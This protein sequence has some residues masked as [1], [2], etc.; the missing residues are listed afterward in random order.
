M[1]IKDIRE[2]KINKLDT[3]SIEVQTRMKVYNPNSYAINVRE[4]NADLFLEGRPAGKAELMEKVH[5]P[6]HFDDYVT[7]MA[8]TDLSAG[9]VQLIPI[10]LGASVK[11]SLEVRVK[12]TAKARSF[13]IGKKVDFD[14]SHQATF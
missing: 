14:Y 13:I 6:A 4:I 10:I 1:E 8:R 12:G 2:I 5:V 7:V 3:K 9:S 11:R